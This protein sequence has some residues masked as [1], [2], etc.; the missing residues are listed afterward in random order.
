MNSENRSS[1]NDAERPSSSGSKT[2]FDMRL[3]Y[4]VVVIGLLG[5]LLA[6]RYGDQIVE[7]EAMA[8]ARISEIQR[9]DDRLRTINELSSDWEAIEQNADHFGATVAKLESHATAIKTGFATFDSENAELMTQMVS[10]TDW[11]V[12]QLRSLSKPNGGS[13]SVSELKLAS[14]RYRTGVETQMGQVLRDEGTA[15]DQEV[16]VARNFKLIFTLLMTTL[17]GVSVALVV[18]ERK[19]AQRRKIELQQS[20]RSRTEELDRAARDSDKIARDLQAKS[21]QLELI[22]EIQSRFIREPKAKAAFESILSAALSLTNSEFGFIGEVLLDD[23]KQPYLRTYAV[24]NIAWNDAMR[25]AYEEQMASG[26]MEFRN[27]DTLFGYCIREGEFVISNHPAD[28]PR[29]G[30]LPPG[31]PPLNSFLGVPIKRGGSMTGMIGLANRPD[32]Y[33]DSSPQDI[34]SVVATFASLIDAR[35]AVDL[36][37]TYENEILTLNQT[38][39]QQVLAMDANVEGLALLDNGRFVYMNPAHARMYGYEVDE[40]VGESWENLYSGSTL[41]EIRQKVF[42]ILQADGD[43]RGELVGTRAD[44]SPV[45]VLVVLTMLPDN[46]LIC[47]CSD[48]G[49]RNRME[50]DLED[51]SAALR[52]ANKELKAAVRSKDEFTASM[53]HELRTPLNAILGY[54][55]LMELGVGGELNPEQRAHVSKLT[56]SAE[57]L[58]ALI[59]D[60]LDLS[61]MNANGGVISASSVNI[62]S[63][64]QSAIELVTGDAKGK[65]IEFSFAPATAGAKIVADERRLRQ[66][67]V[68]L[69]DNAVKFTP[70][71]GRVGL[72]AELNDGNASFEVFDTGIGIQK[73]DFGRIFDPFVQLDQGLNRQFSGTGLGLNLVKRLVDLHG[74]NVTVSS[75]VGKGTRFV[76]RIPSSASAPTESPPPHLPGEVADSAELKSGLRIM[77]VEDNDFNRDTI[78]SFLISEGAQVSSAI[79]GENALE[80]V[81]TLRPDL[82][83]MDIQMPRLDG[84]SAIRRIRSMPKVKETPIVAL[85]A[86]A[87]PGD[88]EKCLQAGADDYL[89]KP[90][91]L[92]HLV[93]VIHRNMRGTTDENA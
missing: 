62:N 72:T 67:L 52:K 15:I 26:G 12:L 9:I 38:L 60:I 58:L 3:E 45:D 36:R 61:L 34:E 6:H 65:Q 88:A 24:T 91:K 37:D 19:R 47:S 22:A 46:Q 54:A 87:L 41:R 7:T 43:W 31:H 74:G 18:L 71:S 8:L 77:L 89:S 75:A 25:K 83:L 64:C 42:P 21:Q 81:E 55:E 53:S 70:E 76:V 85:T 69:L 57:H 14:D 40:L 50:S 78:E 68:N 49:E 59:N 4:L 11:Y 23:S 1:P 29:A 20:V 73:N 16:A 39:E 48:I 92:K 82:I 84:L 13:N 44:G 5:V 79:D 80:M 28:D 93:E 30:G 63:L 2:M 66:V 56:L 33:P 27:L 32:G 90:V 17:V 51:R 86:L 10:L 35:R